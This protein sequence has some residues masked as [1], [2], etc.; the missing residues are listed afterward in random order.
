MSD[1]R[2]GG[3]GVA[4]RLQLRTGWVSLAVW[5]GALVATYAATVSAIDS[6]Y[7][8]PELLQTYG[9]TIGSDPA[10]AAINGTP[11][12]A[13]TLG[14]VA[15]NEFGF[16]AAIAVPLLGLLLVTRGTRAQEESGL[17]ELLRS[18]SVGPR[19]P[20]LAALIVAFGV[21]VLV[22]LGIVASLLA[23]GVGLD[24]AGLYALSIVGLG[25]VFA[26]LATF[27]G[28][29]VR[30][31]SDVIGVG[32]LVLGASYVLRAIGDVKD[33]GWKWLSPLAWQQESRAFA[34]DQRWWP[35]LL[36]YGTAATLVGAGLALVVRRDLG[37]A[38]VP[39]RPGP[40][41][42]SRPLAR[43]IGLAVRGHGPSIVAWALG[44]A[45]VGAVF[46]IFTD[47]IA[48]VINANPS[49]ADV[50]GNGS[51]GGAT[52][53]YVSFVLVLVVLM[54]IGCAAQGIGRIRDE[55]TAGR[56]E[57]VLASSVPRV[58]WLG[59]HSA[60][61]VLGACVVGLAGGAGLAAVVAGSTGG[62]GGGV[63]HASV[64]YLPTVLVI[65]AFGV[66]LV[67]A[68]PRATAAIWAAIAYVALVELLGET[69]SLPE[70]MRSISPLHAIG[71]LPIEAANGSAIA[72]L[73]AVTVGL[74]VAGLVGFRRRDVPR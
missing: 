74:V 32:L 3:L 60:T 8:T 57:P 38:L 44:A 68:L 72:W 43:P 62:G 7:P 10:L 70:W 6:T 12:G 18:R 1:A 27:V 14:G 50:F 17:L 69:L 51:A 19:A 42:A 46:G 63:L 15:A 22:G 21:L 31:G 64:E 13:T 36:A 24:D 39:S 59:V 2:R 61:V 56:L 67:G 71:R 16:I 52:D 41:R 48:E 53:W 37:S 20:W 30:R 9:D 65:G 4:L 11:Y 45:T 28:Q 34:D 40:G 58:R 54:A 55:E 47:D 66:L 5:V 29:L 73:C 49:L 26:S 23:Y 35:L 25:A 33:N